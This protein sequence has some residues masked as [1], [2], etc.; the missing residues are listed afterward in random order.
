MRVLRDTGGPIIMNIAYPGRQNL[1]ALFASLFFL[2]GCGGKT[3]LSDA[4]FDDSYQNRKIMDRILVIAVV[5]NQDARKA[6]EDRFV[7]KLGS[8]ENYAVASHTLSKPDIKPTKEALL[9]ALREAGAQSVYLTR[10]LGTETEQVYHKPMPTGV[11][12]DTQEMNLHGFYPNVYREV[13]TPGYY[14]DETTVTL[15]SRLYDVETAELIWRARSESVNPEL[16]KR[17]INDLVDIF[18]ADLQ[19]KELL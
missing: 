9:A 7:E 17:Y 4:W 14:T 16:N 15:E 5:K 12:E 2:T 1:L 8:F 3:G 6:Y 11:Y 18:T 10:H 19:E 13:Y